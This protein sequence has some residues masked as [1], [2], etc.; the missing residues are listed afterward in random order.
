MSCATSHACFRRVSLLAALLLLLLALLPAA[1]PGA[2]QAAFPGVNGKIAFVRGASI[3]VMMP[4]G[5][6]QTPLPG[7]ASS[8][9]DNPQ[10]SPDGRRIAFTRW[11]ETNVSY[12]Y[13]MNADGSNPVRLRRGNF[14][15]WSPNGARLAFMPFDDGGA[16][17][18]VMNADGSGATPL[19]LPAEVDLGAIS[20]SPDGARLL[21]TSVEVYAVNVDGSNFANLTQS[22]PAHP[23]AMNW[24]A[25]WSPDG[26]KIVYARHLAGGLPWEIVVMDADGG[27]ASVISSHAEQQVGPVWS[28]DGRRIVFARWFNGQNELFSMNVDGS[29]VQQLTNNPGPDMSADWQPLSGTLPDVALRDLGTVGGMGS[30]EAWA[31][32]EAGQATGWTGEGATRHAFHWSPELGMR[33]LGALAA[34]SNSRG[35]YINARG[36]VAGES[37]RQSSAWLPFFWSETTA[38]LCVCLDGMRE[39][40][41][42]GLN[43]Q[44]QVLA[45]ARFSFTD[46]RAYLWTVGGGPAE[47]GSLG[48]TFT[49]GI[50]LNNAGQV[51]GV[52]ADP[53]DRAIPFIWSE[54]TG[55][56][57]FQ[58]L[59]PDVSYQLRD[60]ND[61]G[62]IAG[63]YSRGGMSRP[64]LW[65]ADTGFQDLGTLGG[66]WGYAYYV[67]EAGQVLGQAQNA[68]GRW[69]PFLWSAETGMVDLGGRPF[70]AQDLGDGG[71]AVGQSSYSARWT[72]IHAQAATAAAGLVDLGALYQPGVSSALDANS[73][74]QIAGYSDVAGGARHAVIWTVYNLRDPGRLMQAEVQRLQAGGVLAPARSAEL[75]KK[76]D[77]IAAALWAGD[78][79]AVCGRT[80]SLINMI[81]VYQTRGWLPGDSGD[82]LHSTAVALS[83]TL[84]SRPAVQAAAAE[85][86][87]IQI[88]ESLLY[89]PVVVGR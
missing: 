22:R 56:V 68:A 23:E 70:F 88:E 77:P 58:P 48:G 38:M 62:Q 29:G 7:L 65:S 25:D 74:G 43:D 89:L 26:S 41:V 17:Y 19:P 39:G 60:L 61:R 1:A 28:P 11:D 33:D 53:Q 40:Y 78:A 50:D 52:A 49:S 3:Y 21:I 20:W 27:N 84:C 81:E 76:I 86:V 15:A 83:E 55:L 8:L 47:L 4:D 13:V 69:R 80:P 79:L 34:N 14:A 87:D 31:I 5:S 18:G 46:E 73:S 57:P 67:N 64:F 10:W 35:R 54:A 30:S 71:L 32:N 72:T 75:R 37:T 63:D 59:G 51:I 42:Q 2:V 16:R 12:I 44:G 85:D 6:G 24:S 66:Q 45:W 82:L 36:D 9:S